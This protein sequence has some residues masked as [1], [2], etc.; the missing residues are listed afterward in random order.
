MGMSATAYLLYGVP[1]GGGEWDVT[2]TDH[3][4]EDGIW[5]P[6]WADPDSDDDD[7]TVAELV[8]TRLHETRFSETYNGRGELTGVGVTYSGYLAMGADPVLRAFEL[9]VDAGDLSAQVD[10]TVLER[11]RVSEGWDGMLA[12]A[13]AALEITTAPAPGWHL[14]AN[15]G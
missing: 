2:F 14:V 10:F 1:L 15:Y 5:T 7:S 8:D 6:P 11:R 12:A 4:G 9:R 3:V 13:L